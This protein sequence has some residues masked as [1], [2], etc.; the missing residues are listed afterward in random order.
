MWCLLQ[1]MSQ[2]EAMHVLWQQQGG[3]IEL[4]SLTTISTDP[5]RPS[6]TIPPPFPVWH[7]LKTHLAWHLVGKIQIL[8]C[9]ISSH[10]GLGR[11]VNPR[12]SSHVHVQRRSYNTECNCSPAST[13]SDV[14]P[15]LMIMTKS[16]KRHHVILFESDRLSKS[17]FNYQ[18]PCS[19]ETS[20]SGVACRR[21]IQYDY[22]IK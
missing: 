13:I 20:I 10:L 9:G 14:I 15:P 21:M 5:W 4:E 12:D 3:I 18:I 17:V 7:S 11:R 19:Q 16:L 6:S 8:P 1:G 22:T 2:F